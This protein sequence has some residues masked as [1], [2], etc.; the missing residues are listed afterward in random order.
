MK[1]TGVV[2]RIDELGRIVIPKELRRSLRI[3]EGDSVEIYIDENHAIVLKK[4]SPVENVK[5]FITQYL[6]SVY[7]ATKKDIIIVDSERVVA[8][9]GEFKKELI[10]RKIDLRLEEKIQ[11]R[12]LQIY[13]KGDFIEVCDGLVLNVNTVI[14]PISCY[15]D[16]IG[17]VILASSKI[18]ESDVSLV[19]VSASFIGKYLEN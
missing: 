5:S 4:Y 17:A 7:H 2:R 9:C 1:A 8:V 3:K 15:G 13:N 19:E 6:E 12:S 11:N 18:S 16:K 14:K 10:G